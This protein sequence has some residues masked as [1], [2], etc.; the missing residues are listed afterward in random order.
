MSRIS[1][2]YESGFNLIRNCYSVFQAGCIQF[3]FP[4]QYLNS[5]CSVFSPVLISF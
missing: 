1:G 3:E 5:S 2:L 4:L